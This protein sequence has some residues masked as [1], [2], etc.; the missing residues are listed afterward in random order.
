MHARVTRAGTAERAP[1]IGTCTGVLV[2]KGTL[3][4]VARQIRMHARVTRAE[5]RNVH[6]QL[7]HV[8]VFLSRKVHWNTLRDR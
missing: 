4:H 6:Q 8:L 7:V 3:E 1:T 5:R 2:P